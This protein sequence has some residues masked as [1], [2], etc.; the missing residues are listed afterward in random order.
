[1]TRDRE[2]RTEKPVY[3][4]CSLLLMYYS[5]TKLSLDSLLIKHPNL[6]FFVHEILTDL[7]FYLH[8]KCKSCFLWSFSL[9]LYLLESSQSPVTVSWPFNSQTSLKNL[10]GRIKLL[11]PQQYIQK[12]SVPMESDEI[13]EKRCSREK[14]DLETYC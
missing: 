3:K 8:K 10:V 9:D 2:C 5:K 11:P 7:L 4:P 1:M 14:G 12:A 13:I 6:R